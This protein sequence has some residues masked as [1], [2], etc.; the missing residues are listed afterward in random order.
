MRNFADVVTLS[1]GSGNDTIYSSGEAS[2]LS[3]GSGK[4]SLYNEGVNAILLGGSDKDTL[5]NE[6]EHVTIAG[7]TGN[8][9]ISNKGKHIVYQFGTGDGKDTVVGFNDG[10]TVQIT[11]G[12]YT[13]KKSGKNVI[14]SIGT[15]KLTLRDAADKT[16]NFITSSDVTS[17]SNSSLAKDIRG[18][19]GNDSLW[20]GKGNDSLY[21]GAGDD[22]FIYTTNEGTNTIFDYSSGDM[23]QILNADGSAGSF[24]SS[25]FS[26]GDLTLTIN[27]GGCVI[28]SGVSAGDKFNINNKTY[29]LGSKKL[30]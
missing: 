20:G 9:S 24:K 6:G 25:K 8:D 29:T 17:A 19:T 22:T 28:F 1:G 15:D 27:G 30:K 16:I 13:S 11:E 10:D 26:G 18:G 2:T 3:G 4:D 7:G 21:G 23:L 5:Y 14:V 12:N